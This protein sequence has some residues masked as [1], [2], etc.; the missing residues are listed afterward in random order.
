IFNSRRVRADSAA[1]GL[2]PGFD[3]NLYS[4]SYPKQE[5]WGGYTA[6]ETKI[7]DDQLRLFGDFYY[8]DSKT[9]DEL[10]PIA[11]GSFVTP[12]SPILFIPPNHPF[13]GGVPPFGGPTP[14]EV[15]LPPGAFNPF[16]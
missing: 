11:T 3:F 2:L 8:V 4:S 10:A 13:P 6:F 9:H 7:C 5:R 14:S 16:N 15:G 1:G 12:G